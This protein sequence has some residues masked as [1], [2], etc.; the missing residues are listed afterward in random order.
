MSEYPIVIAS[1]SE[2]DGGGFVG[3]VPDL[4]GCMSDGETADE[5][6][7]NTRE[8]IQEWIA[9]AKRR[10]MNI[11]APN[12]N[13]ARAKREQE[14]LANTL[15]TIVAKFDQMDSRIG[16][17][18]KLTKN[19]EERLDHEDAWSRFAEVARAVTFE[20]PASKLHS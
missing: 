5:A 18:E 17:L 14:H 10:G 3:V 12:S 11:P 4:T 2:E 19:V 13:A 20:T 15:R 8:A 16:E 9:T 6:L 1:L 7:A